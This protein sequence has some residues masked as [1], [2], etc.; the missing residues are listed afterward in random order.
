MTQTSAATVEHP[1]VPGAFDTGSPVDHD[2]GRTQR[3][4]SALT[5]PILDEPFTVDGIYR[6]YVLPCGH[7]ISRQALEQVSCRFCMVHAPTTQPAAYTAASRAARRAA[8][9]HSQPASQRTIITTPAPS[10]TFEFCRYCAQARPDVLWTCQI[11]RMH[12]CT[13]TKSTTPWL[14]PSWRRLIA[15]QAPEAAWWTARAVLTPKARQSARARC[16]LPRT[17]PA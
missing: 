13:A 3:M 16:A 15:T 4:A 12:S 8:A 9:T 6:P 7:T 1:S 2:A 10:C 5:C 11:C 14:M 17:T